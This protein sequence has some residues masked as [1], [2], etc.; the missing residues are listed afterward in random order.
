VR[1]FSQRI[2]G[3]AESQDLMVRQNWRGA[4][5]GDLVRD[6]STCSAP[7]RASRY[8]A[9]RYSSRQCRAEYRLRSAE[10]ATNASKHG[11]LA[12]PEGACW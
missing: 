10:L 5:L 8:M 6:I 4:W 11:A 7:A 3:L 2:L 1:Q 12:S 9:P